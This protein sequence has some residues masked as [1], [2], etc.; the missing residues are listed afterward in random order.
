MNFFR[1]IFGITEDFYGEATRDEEWNVRTFASEAHV[2]A[3]RVYNGMGV[4]N[5]IWR[6]RCKTKDQLVLVKLRF[7]NSPLWA[8]FKAREKRIKERGPL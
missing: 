4:Q 3:D 2:V 5:D 7:G 1:R 8:E 6:F